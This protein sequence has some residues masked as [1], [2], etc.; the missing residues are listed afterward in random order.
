MN[1]H[2]P[3]KK[4][5]DLLWSAKFMLSLIAILT[6]VLVATQT[7]F[8]LASA[9]LQNGTYTVYLPSVITTT[10]EIEPNETFDSATSLHDLNQIY[11][12]THA[13]EDRDF[14]RL[15]IETA[16]KLSVHLTINENEFIDQATNVFP[17][18]AVQLVL[19]DSSSERVVPLIG[20]PPYR[21][22]NLRL[23]R[24]VY[25]ILVFTAAD[26]ADNVSY[27]LELSFE[28]DFIPPTATP[29]NTATPTQTPVP[30]E[31]ATPEPPTMT[32]T[33]TPTEVV[34]NPPASA[35]I[36]VAD[37]ISGEETELCVNAG[38]QITV[39]ASGSIIVGEF[40]GSAGPE[41]KET[42]EVIGVPVSID[43]S[44]DIIQEFP[45]AALMYRIENAQTN[46][47]FNEGW[48]SYHNE[49]SFT[50]N[51]TGCLAFD[52]NDI[53]NNDNSGSFDVTINTSQ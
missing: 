41:G 31:T 12:G 15:N 3:F 10:Q 7:R 4:K 45:H 37:Y 26:Q 21:I 5:L 2:I 24:E 30:T 27:S 23:T 47:A 17:E 6:I 52:I 20:E 38:N 35:S 9:Q 8:G 25:Y 49:K 51:M 34:F 1:L 18:N 11:Q 42:F 28:P 44:L 46:Y 14:F 22:D 53:D 48:K 29:I 33:P 16:G 39:E 36:D 43:P 40:V 32:P 19:E 13:T 50:A